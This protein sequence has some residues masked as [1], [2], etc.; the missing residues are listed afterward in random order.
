MAIFVICNKLSMMKRLTILLVAL[1][2]L[3]LASFAQNTLSQEDISNIESYIEQIRS[4]WKIPGMGVS[5]LKD[6]ELILCKGYGVKNLDNPQDSVDSHT[7]FQIGSVSK[8]FTAYLLATLV[9]EGLISWDNTVKEILPDF[10]MYD[11]W[12]TEHLQVKDLTSHKTGIGRQVGT[13]IPNL[14][15]DRDDIYRM[16]ELIEPSY[17]FRGAYQYNNIT[18]IPAARIIEKVT[19]KSWEDNIRERIFEPLGMDESTINGEGFA[20]AQ[21]VALPYEFLS[22]EGKMVINPLYGEEQALWWLTVI[23]PAGSICCPPKDL[24]KWAQFQLDG[25]KVDGKELISKKNMDYLHR[26]VTITSQSESKT[27]LY[28]HCWFIEQSKKGRI[29]FHT[30]TTWGMTTLC[31]FVPEL[32]LGLTIQVNSEAPSEPRYAVLRR[33]VDLC[34]DLEDYDYNAEFLKEWYANAA[35]K[36]EEEEKA[37]AE[38][39]V[40]PAPDS[41]LLV[42]KYT[43][44]PLFG[45]AWITLEKGKLYIKIGKQGWKHEMTHVS[46]NIYKF[47]SDGTAFEIKF[48]FEEGQKKAASF[49]VDFKEGEDFGPWTRLSK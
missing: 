41:K 6:G 12:V 17:T 5:I 39:V 32:D 46:G 23:G 16:L 45:D 25:G 42:G 4:D 31:A 13:Y 8:S 18:F 22:K 44:D 19:G 1:I 9:D 3:P 43:K 20:E 33:L 28:S 14:G 35:K 37:A 2:W 27:T 47:R 15:Y 11:P 48:K 29:Y 24:I 21:N 49:E 38:K 40:E 10:K 30:G 34:L 26:G 7:L 36:A